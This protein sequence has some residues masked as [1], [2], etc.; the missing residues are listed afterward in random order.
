MKRKMSQIRAEKK[1]EEKRKKLVTISI[2]LTQS[3]S[4]VIDLLRGELTKTAFIK[5]KLGL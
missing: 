4:A 5:M 1:Y 3:E 2:R